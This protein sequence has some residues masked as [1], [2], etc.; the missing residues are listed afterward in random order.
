M[1]A[2][3][4]LGSAFVKALTT[5]EPDD[6]EVQLTVV[7]CDASGKDLGD[8]GTAACSLETLVKNGKD[9]VGP[10]KLIG[11]NGGVGE[12]VCE[13]RGVDALKEL[14]TSGGSRTPQ[15]GGKGRRDERAASAGGD[16]GDGS[17][18]TPV[19]ISAG[20]FEFEGGKPKK[21]GM[22]LE[23]RLSGGVEQSGGNVSK[24]AL[25]KSKDKD[26][27][28]LSKTVGLTDGSCVFGVDESIIATKGSGLAS[29]LAA[30]AGGASGRA[31]AERPGCVLFEVFDQSD[32]SKGKTVHTLRDYNPQ[33]ASTTRNPRL[34]PATRVSSPPRAPMV[35]LLTRPRCSWPLFTPP[36]CVFEPSCGPGRRERPNRLESD[37]HRRVRP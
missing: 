33:P 9:H 14:S 2:G 5:D 19:G 27:P 4:P 35:A 30:A 17:S 11:T 29:T 32:K 23:V 12:V 10:L 3:S 34:Q 18:D 36:S 1:T 7:A 31:S 22:R 21:T 13:I 24:A 8:I 25:P 15:R 37:P 28:L 16:G 6:S 20:K 26:V